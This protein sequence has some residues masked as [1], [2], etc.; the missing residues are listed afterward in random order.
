MMR[1]SVAAIGLAAAM[2]LAV[3]AAQAQMNSQGTNTQQRGTTQMNPPPGGST[4]GEHKASKADQKF[5]TEA[6]QGD[7][8]EIQVG[9]LAQQKGQSDEVK[10]F[11]KMLEQDHSE[12]LQKAQSEAQQLGVNA[13]SEPSAK[14]KSAYEKLSKASDAR[15]DREFKQAM[16]KDHKED[17][18]KY[19]KEAKSKGPLADFAQQTLPVLEKHLK[20]AEQLPSKGA[21]VGSGKRQ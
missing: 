20:T 9:K 14:Q 5:M 19:Q 1:N 17:I 15:F 6:I 3:S 21:T 10:Q 11:G 4:A 2:A 16:I 7:L 18:A 12:H 8:A 13:P